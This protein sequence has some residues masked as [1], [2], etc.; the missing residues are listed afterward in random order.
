MQNTTI[1]L[2]EISGVSSGPIEKKTSQLTSDSCLSRLNI[3]PPI[4]G[5]VCAAGPSC[6]VGIR[7]FL[8]GTKSDRISSPLSL[9]SWVL[10][11]HRSTAIGSWASVSVILAERVA[12]S[13]YALLQ[14]CRGGA[15][16]WI[17]DQ[18]VLS[19]SGVRTPIPIITTY[20][21]PRPMRKTCLKA[22]VIKTTPFPQTP[23]RNLGLREES[24][25][26]EALTFLLKCSN[27]TA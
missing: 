5:I 10:T 4:C 27:N 17:R 14:C 22:P 13:Y 12:S 7:G 20:V 9:S 1:G 6:L 25:F 18:D 11:F 21:V 24:V 26:V 2:S 3:R 15:F 19:A 8:T 23:L 16:G